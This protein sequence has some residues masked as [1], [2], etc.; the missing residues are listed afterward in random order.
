MQKILHLIAYSEI[1]TLDN[2]D[3]HVVSRRTDIFKFLA[4]EDVNSNH[5]NL[6]MAMFAGLGCGHFHNFARPSLQL[7]DV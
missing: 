3:I 1:F 5:V 6:S 4:I 2:W 7:K